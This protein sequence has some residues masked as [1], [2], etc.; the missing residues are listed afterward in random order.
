MLEEKLQVLHVGERQVQ[1][2]KVLQ[3]TRPEVA[4]ATPPDH[5]MFFFVF[6]DATEGNHF[7]CDKGQNLVYLDLRYNKV[8]SFAVA[9]SEGSEGRLSKKASGSVVKAQGGL[10]R[11]G[12][13]SSQ[14]RVLFFPAGGATRSTSLK[15]KQQPYR[16]V[17]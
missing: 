17:F 1:C 6:L 5:S 9:S 4:L 16:S 11:V 8:G 13:G 14:V 12:F 15:V 3:A 2:C 7:V 10:G